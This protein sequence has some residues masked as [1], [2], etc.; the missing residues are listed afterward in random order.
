M[1]GRNALTRPG[2]PEAFVDNYDEQSPNLHPRVRQQ[3]D[4]AVDAMERSQLMR[5]A[6]TADM[7]V[8][9]ALAAVAGMAQQAGFAL[10][11]RPS[12]DDLSD[13]IEAASTVAASDG[14]IAMV[15]RAAKTLGMPGMPTRS[16]TGPWPAMRDADYVFGNARPRS[17]GPPT[18][19][20]YGAER[21]EPESSAEPAP[22][23]DPFSGTV[24]NPNYAAEMDRQ[25]ANPGPAFG[26][27]HHMTTQIENERP[28]AE[29]AFGDTQAALRRYYQARGDA[30][31]RNALTRPGR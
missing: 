7:S 16:E 25:V 12:R 15:V 4:P 31:A 5:G 6:R 19:D 17:F 14:E 29:A 26:L 20:G 27:Y 3:F 10:P 23:S 18:R 30:R 13:M 8:D 21:M 11:E 28:G 2:G 9:Q 24:R 1:A 22:Q